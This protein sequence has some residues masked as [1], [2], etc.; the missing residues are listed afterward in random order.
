MTSDRGF[1][2][3][4]KR[5]QAFATVREASAKRSRVTRGVSRSAVKGKLHRTRVPTAF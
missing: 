5:P 4:A 2:A 3:F 1:K